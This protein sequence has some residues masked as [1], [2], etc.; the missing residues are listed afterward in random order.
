MPPPSLAQPPTSVE[1]PPRLRS[2]TSFVCAAR[3]LCGHS[4]AVQ[5]HCDQLT[6]HSYVLSLRLTL[7]PFSP[8]SAQIVESPPWTCSASLPRKQV[9][10]SIKSQLGPSSELLFPA[11]PGWAFPPSLRRT[12]F[13]PPAP[14]DRVLGKLRVPLTSLYLNRAI[15]HRPQQWRGWGLLHCCQF[16][17]RAYLCLHTVLSCQRSQ[18]RCVTT[19]LNKR[20]LPSLSCY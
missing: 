18:G 11:S 8:P 2:L 14:T 15:I 13:T 12:R 5:A 6:H 1:T 20:C 7:H 16:S 3:E 17:S 10:F 4:L 9:P 19:R